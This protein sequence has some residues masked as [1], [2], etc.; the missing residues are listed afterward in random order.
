VVAVA[1]AVEVEVEVEVVAVAVDVAA[2]EVV[3]A[4]VPKN[5][6]ILEDDEVAV[7]ASVTYA[8][9]AAGAQSRVQE[10]NEAVPVAAMGSAATPPSRPTGRRG[11]A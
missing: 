10:A 9:S 3:A 6:H 2:V 8:V 7:G 5:R 1:V 4:A 11:G